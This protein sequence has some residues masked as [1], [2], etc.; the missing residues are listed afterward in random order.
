MYSYVFDPKIVSPPFLAVSLLG[1]HMTRT[2]CIEH[3]LTKD[4]SESRTLI[5]PQN[6]NVMA[7]ESPMQRSLLSVERCMN[8]RIVEPKSS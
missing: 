4:F 5:V 3:V 7:P 1:F 2:Y 8:L 6:L